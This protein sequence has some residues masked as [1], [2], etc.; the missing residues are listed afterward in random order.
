MMS[1]Q[2]Q[3]QPKLF[4]NQINLDE[5]ISQDHPLRAVKNTVDFNFIY[6]E[7]QHLYGTKGNPSVPPPVILKM[8]FLFF[9]YNVRSERELMNTITLR[10]DWIWFLD[11][12]IDDEIPN[13]SV[14]S[15]AR[16]RWGTRAFETFFERVVSQC[17]H[18]NLVDGNKIFMDASFVQADASN[19]SIINRNSLKRYMNKS[20]RRLVSNLD[21]EDT[22]E[23]KTGKENSKYLS[24]T[25]P[26]ASLVRTFNSPSKLRYKT[27]RAVD[28]KK[29]IITA[30]TVSPGASNEA[31]LLNELVDQHESNTNQEVETVVADSKY[32]TNDNY[33]N[34]HDR[35]LKPHFDSLKA[36]SE[37]DNRRI[38]ILPASAFKYD[39]KTDSFTCPEGQQL[40]RRRYKKDRKQFE[41]GLAKKICNACKLKDKCTRSKRGR[42]LKRHIRQDDLDQML[43][44]SQSKRSQEDIRKRQHLME[45][46]FA[47]SVRYGFKRSRWRRLW[48]VKIQEYMI[49]TIQNIMVLVKNQQSKG[50][51]TGLRLKR[52][53][54]GHILIKLTGKIKNGAHFDWIFMQNVVLS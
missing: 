21:L 27:H 45:R 39:S 33:L 13:H 49:S 26:D 17:V 36:T 5:R 2:S 18:E 11:Y 3:V 4:Y 38:G 15:K 37:K 22:I 8:M 23:S 9:F 19:N 20:Y 52:V 48:R 24:T 54:M 6:D 43:K 25:D 50:H 28:E 10:L 12:D 44:E 42:T 35:G 14:L 29:E 31:H 34:C 30:T 1:K 53:K 7:V 41:Y 51:R 47:H 16:K 32:G 40:T 46:S